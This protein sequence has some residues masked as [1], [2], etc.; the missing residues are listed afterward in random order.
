MEDVRFEELKSELFRCG[1]QA[2]EDFLGY[3]PE[4]DDDK[5]SI[6]ERMDE[7][8][9]QM[10]E[11]VLEEYYKDYKIGPVRELAGDMVVCYEAVKPGMMRLYLNGCFGPE[12]EDNRS[13]LMLIPMD[14][15]SEEID[16]LSDMWLTE[17][18]K[19]MGLPIGEFCS[20]SSWWAGSKDDSHDGEITDKYDWLVERCYT[21]PERESG[22]LDAQIQEAAGQRVAR[23]N[24]R[25][26]QGL[27]RE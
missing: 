24:G 4:W 18:E 26:E 3:E 1:T 23:C 12:P 20:S 9:E 5:D 15:A 25:T 21:K 22:S 16:M 27:N 6:D 7:V 17:Q 14:M 8:Y 11:D 10:P 19:E 2:I 13:T